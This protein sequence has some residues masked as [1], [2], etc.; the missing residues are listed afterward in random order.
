M[1]EIILITQSADKVEEFSR[2]LGR[3]VSHRHLDLPE[4]QSLDP[5]EVAAH[6]AGAA[7][8]ILS[9]GPVMVEDTGLAVRAWNG[10]PGALIKWF[11]RGVGPEGLCRMAAALEGGAE[12]VAETA[13]AVCDG[14]GVRVF[15]GKVEGVI[16]PRPSGSGGFG[17]DSVFKPAGEARTFAEMSPEEKDAYSMRRLALE[18]LRANYPFT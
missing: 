8:D 12:A 2:L 5:A 1:P 16:A 10:L 15:S 18:N 6:K 7:F 14:G 4:I 11:L 13:I 9:G 3:A 17:W